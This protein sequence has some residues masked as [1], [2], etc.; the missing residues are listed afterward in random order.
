MRI[1]HLYKTYWP[2]LGGMENH[3]RAL[4][5]AQ[6]RAGHQ[7]TVL[8]TDHAAAAGVDGDGSAVKVVRVRER[9]TLARVPLAPGLLRALA[10][11]SP[12][13]THLHAPYPIGELAQLLAGRARPYVVTDQADVIRPDQPALLALYG[14]LLRLV[15]R[16]ARRVLATSPRYGLTSTTCWLGVTSTLGKAIP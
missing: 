1:L 14:P 12:D 11:E 2:V 3:V 7:V 10:R 9:L 5:L 15:L 6:A 16:R 4:A 8:A 13:I